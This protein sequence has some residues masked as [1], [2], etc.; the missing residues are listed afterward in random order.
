MSRAAT[1]SGTVCLT[2]D[3]LGM[4]LEVGRRRAARPDPD[5]PGLRTGVPALLALFADLGVTSTFFVEG[6]NGLHH[7]DVIQRIGMAGHEIGLHGW[8]HE[9]WADDLDDRDREQLLWDGTAALRSAG[10]DPVAFRA[11]GGY[12]GEA[13]LDVLAE[14][15]YGIDSSIERDAGFEGQQLAVSLLPHGIVSI[16][17]TWDMIDFWQYVS[18][19]DGT[20]DPAFLAAHWT[21]LL[22]EAA[23]RSGLVTLI[24]HPFVTG[25]DAD[26]LAALRRVL[27][28]ALSHPRL[29]VASA[30]DVARVHRLPLSGASAT[31]PGDCA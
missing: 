20:R 14:L 29:T 6:W 3:N 27:E 13:T 10:A 19:P 31:T 22:D 30:E 7:P 28:H 25:I 1:P 26:R 24:V 23:E 18:R 4:A 21:A 17:W 9:R 5:E 2:V 12:R 8:V 15:G 16:P 11:P